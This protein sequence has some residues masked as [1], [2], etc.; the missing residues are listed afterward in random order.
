MTSMVLTMKIIEL[1][2]F[3]WERPASRWLSGVH[4][5]KQWLT[6]NAKKAIFSGEKAKV[7]LSILDGCVCV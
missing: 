1:T 3:R 2:P 7:V 5:Y 6:K 4:S